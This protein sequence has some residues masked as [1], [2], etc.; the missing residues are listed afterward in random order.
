MDLRK[1][2]RLIESLANQ[3][4]EAG[5]AGMRTPHGNIAFVAKAIKNNQRKVDAAKAFLAAASLKTRRSALYK[6]K[7]RAVVKWSKAIEV[8]KQTAA[9]L[10]KKVRAVEPGDITARVGGHA[11]RKDAKNKRIAKA[12]IAGAFDAA[13]KDEP[14]RAIK[15]E[16]KK[17]GAKNAAELKNLDQEL[18]GFSVL[19]FKSINPT[20][21]KDG[22]DR[23]AVAAVAAAVAEK[24]AA[25]PAK[26]GKGKRFVNRVPARL[27]EQA[28]LTESV[29]TQGKMDK[30]EGLG[31]AGGMNATFTAMAVHKDAD[32]KPVK[33]RVFI[34]P[35]GP[36]DAVAGQQ[37]RKGRGGKGGFKGTVSQAEREVIAYELD[38]DV[39]GLD[40]VSPTLWRDDLPQMDGMPE[41]V[42]QLYKNDGW[43]P[44]YKAVATPKGGAISTGIPGREAKDCKTALVEASRSH[45]RYHRMVAL[46]W[47][48]G[49]MDRHNKNWKVDDD[50]V[51]HAFD[52]GLAFP[53]G[54]NP[55]SYM[56]SF[57]ASYLDN[58]PPLPEVKEAV[59]AISPDKV[60]EHLSRYPFKNDEADGVVKRLKT[61]Q[62]S[63]RDKGVFPKWP[64][65]I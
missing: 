37:A 38:R 36:G 25:K 1:T 45:H 48:I 43:L 8:L 49:A 19:G 31:G 24:Q 33:V 15:A 18:E 30:V 14:D 40:I 53:A 60:T 23:V 59:L 55:D 12:K 50:A 52:H 64:G 27:T 20:G 63:F 11:K 39:L 16:I 4:A 22:P 58:K 51:P 44:K 62:D 2:A 57:P 13:I 35:N 65:N 47:I 7:Q 21:V 34:K 56:R 26:L 5:V 10:M 41:K 29:I 28:R 46:D 9:D 6:Q 17:A 54:D 61:L 3:L 42:E 32:D